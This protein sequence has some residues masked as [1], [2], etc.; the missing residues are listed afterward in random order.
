M[1]TLRFVAAMSVLL[2][3][4]ACEKQDRDSAPEAC[5]GRHK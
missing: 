3:I 5:A 2:A 1:K 4:V